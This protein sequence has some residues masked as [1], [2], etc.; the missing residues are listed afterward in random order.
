MQNAWTNLTLA[1]VAGQVK[2]AWANR[3][4]V[5]IL[6]GVQMAWNHLTLGRDMLTR[7]H[8]YT[9]TYTHMEKQTQAH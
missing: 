9:H 1:N 4:P 7:A 5:T 3:Y 8:T 2:T 6:S